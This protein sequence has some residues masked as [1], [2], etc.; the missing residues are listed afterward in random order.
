MHATADSDADA[1]GRFVLLA[2]CER[3]LLGHRQDAFRTHVSRMR[4]HVATLPE[5]RA[6]EMMR[7]EGATATHGS[8]TLCLLRSRRRVASCIPRRDVARSLCSLKDANIS[9]TPPSRGTRRSCQRHDV[10]RTA[11]GV[12]WHAAPGGTPHGTPLMEIR[13][14]GRT[15][16]S[17]PRMRPARDALPCSVAPTDV[18][19]PCTAG[20]AYTARPHH[21]RLPHSSSN[22]HSSSAA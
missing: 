22:L 16:R 8:S 19:T 6:E 18:R 7:P 13:I 21:A 11:G 2:V 10:P 4:S 1:L 12:A 14:D 15:S 9:P 20:A 17:A 3:S 5:T